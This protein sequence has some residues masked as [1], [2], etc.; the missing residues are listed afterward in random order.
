MTETGTIT[1][2]WGRDKI[3]EAATLIAVKKEDRIREYIIWSLRHEAQEFCNIQEEIMEI[4]LHPEK[5][6]NTK[7]RL[8]NLIHYRTETLCYMRQVINDIGLV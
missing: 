3:K 8:K 7:E 2:E 1:C 6:E 5:P 4:L